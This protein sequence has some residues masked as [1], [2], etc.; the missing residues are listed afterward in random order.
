MD[1]D[2]IHQGQVQLKNVYPY[3]CCYFK[4]LF[5]A[6]KLLKLLHGEQAEIEIVFK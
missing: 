3:K 5:R 4:I 1:V 2:L 6:R